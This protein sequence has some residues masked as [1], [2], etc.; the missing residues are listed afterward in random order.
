MDEPQSSA[1]QTGSG[2]VPD[3]APRQHPS[4]NISELGALAKFWPAEARKKI[5]TAF[6]EHDGVGVR[7]AES[8]NVT[9]NGLNKIVRRLDLGDAIDAACE[10]AGYPRHRGRPRGAFDGA[11]RTTVRTHKPGGA[12]KR[13]RPP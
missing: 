2:T 7:A 6:L 12:K 3:V 11:P 8:L 13:R 5:L 10:A 9:Y 1:A 4:Q